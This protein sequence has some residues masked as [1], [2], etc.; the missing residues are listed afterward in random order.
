MIKLKHQDGNS[1]KINIINQL[2]SHLWNLN[3][4][5]HNL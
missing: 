5:F 4:Q 3:N 2:P 1:L